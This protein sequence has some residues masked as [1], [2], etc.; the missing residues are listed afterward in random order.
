MAFD[1]LSDRPHT[2]PLPPFRMARW[3]ED[4]GRDEQVPLAFH[5]KPLLV[6][7]FGPRQEQERWLFHV[8]PQGERA[9]LTSKV[10]AATRSHPSPGSSKTRGVP[11]E[12]GATRT[13][14]PTNQVRPPPKILARVGFG[15]GFLDFHHGVFWRGERAERVP[16]GT[17][18]L[19]GALSRRC[20]YFF[21]GRHRSF[22]D[23]VP[24]APRWTEMALLSGSCRP[25]EPLS[26]WRT[27]ASIFGGSRFKGPSPESRP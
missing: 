8:E 9:L 21:A 26:A 24:S 22:R 10:S 27:G 5:V 6:G 2:A 1:Q 17:S 18:V 16:R 7:T 12:I 15:K 20:L 19:R 23:N 25:N 11:R 4:C 3:V 14:P 13:A